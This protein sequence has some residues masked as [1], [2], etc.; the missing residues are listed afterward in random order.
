MLRPGRAKRLTVYVNESASWHGHTLRDAIL[1]LLLAKGVAGGTVIRSVAGYTRNKGIVTAKLVDLSVD[2]PIR[3]EAVDTAEAIDRVL[4]DIYLM[5]ETGLVTV[6]EVDV[7]KY[8]G[9]PLSPTPDDREQTRRRMTMMAKQIAIH[10][11]ANDL[12]ND[13]PLH[14]AILKRFNMEGFA[15]ATVFKALEGFGVSHAIH[16]DRLFSLHRE[17][18]ILVLMVDTE[19]NVAKAKAILDGMLSHGAV[20]ISDVELTYYGRSSAGKEVED[21]AS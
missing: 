9:E 7:V 8:T 10:I 21:P 11:S 6:D 14:E 5:V 1:E 18:P 3:I 4:P 12:Y 16:R 13:E 17:G 19:Q 15:G 20:V 2:L